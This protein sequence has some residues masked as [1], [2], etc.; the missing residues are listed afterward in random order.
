MTMFI[1]KFA[2]YLIFGKISQ[3]YKEHEILEMKPIIEDSV[4]IILHCLLNIL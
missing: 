3:G 4:N 1:K 2:S